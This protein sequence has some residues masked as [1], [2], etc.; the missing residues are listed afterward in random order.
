MQYIVISTTHTLPVA[1][2]HGNVALARFILFYLYVFFFWVGQHLCI[3]STKDREPEPSWKKKKT[4]GWIQ[5]TF[6][7]STCLKHTLIWFSPLKVRPD[8]TGRRH[9]PW[10]HPLQRSG[11]TRVKANQLRGR[12]W[13]LGCTS[14]RI[15]WSNLF[16]TLTRSGT[17]RGPG[18]HA[19]LVQFCG[20]L[21]RFVHRL[22]KMSRSGWIRT[23]G[24]LLDKAN[25]HRFL[26]DAKLT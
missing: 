19:R 26:L 23:S 18:F 21:F 13:N 7:I 24:V 2:T 3:V 5:W 16:A 8:S 4:V 14:T 10:R 17:H 22:T 6:N 15:R 12:S 9:S 1:W 11:F 25:A 20:F